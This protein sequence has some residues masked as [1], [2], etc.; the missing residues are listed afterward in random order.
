MTDSQSIPRTLIAGALGGAWGGAIVGLAEATVITL[1]TAPGEEYWL[2]PYAVV[3]YGIL[4]MAVGLV[5]ALAGAVVMPQ[6]VRRDALGF[7]A[8]GAFF[9]IGFAVARYHIIQRVFHEEL[10]TTSGIGLTV[11]AGVLVC[12]G[13]LALALLY[14]GRRLQRSHGGLVLTAL[15]LVACLG[16]SSGTAL[17]ASPHAREPI[18]SRPRGATAPAAPNVILIILDT[19]RADALG[20]YGAAATA[21]PALDA[22]AGEAVRFEN[23]YAQSSWTRPSIATILTSLYP[24]QHGAMHKMDALPDQVTTLAEA[25][26]AKGYWTAGFVSNINVA[27]VFNFQQGFDE[28]TYLAPDFYFW[29]TDSATQLAIYKGLRLARERFLRDRIYF[30]N[31]YQDAEVVTGAVTQWVEHTPPMPF[32]LFI[33][34]M[35]PHDPYFE[36]PYDGRG[37][38]RVSNPDP[39]ASRKDE[40]HAL[41]AKDVTY[42]DQHLGGLLSRLK[43]AGVYENTIIAVTAD[44]GE[45]FQEHGGWWHGTSLY[46]E[47]VHVPLIV[48][49]AHE[50]HAG[51][52]ESRRA[53]TLD[54]APT[55]MAAAGLEIPREFVGRDLF[56]PAAPEP[57]PLF[58]EEELEG[59][60]L[61]SLRV[62]PWKVIT[63][64]A[65]NPRGL[66]P[67]ELYNLDQDAHERHNLALTERARAEQ[68]LGLLAQERARLHD[69]HHFA[70]RMSPANVADHRS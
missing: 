59:N 1:S 62:G 7:A 26:H 60:V 25:L 20:S 2:F 11:H 3:S 64:N 61:A 55:L 23:T 19:L 6:R 63:A 50:E 31:Y 57:E 58:A 30:Y 68:M 47:V 27:P 37:V 46:Q 8:A 9:L 49:R 48:K 18:A 40:L 54:I 21:S 56:G 51:Q 10:A 16:V 36:I 38:A 43:S 33:H 29:A 65:D 13:A 42:L 52:V 35:D 66:Q 4:G 22:F 5:S 69:T 14:G 12:V 44:H 67:L 45:E 32:F 41:Y 24:S 15:A 28:Y 39:P 17:V 34:F 70:A 53:R